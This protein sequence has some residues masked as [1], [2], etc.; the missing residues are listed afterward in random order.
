MRSIDEM[1]QKTKDKAED[2]TDK[3]KAKAHE[4]KGRLDEKIKQPSKD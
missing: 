3:V 1:T 4:T 2:M